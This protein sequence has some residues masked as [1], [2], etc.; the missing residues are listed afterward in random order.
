M[1]AL[2]CCATSLVNAYRRV[3][4]APM[5]PI[6]QPCQ[7]A[8]HLSFDSTRCGQTLAGTLAF[9]HPAVEAAVSNWA[10]MLQLDI[11]AGGAS[12]WESSKMAKATNDSLENASQ[13]SNGCGPT[14]CCHRD[15]RSGLR[16]TQR[17][18]CSA[19]SELPCPNAAPTLL[20]QSWSCTSLWYRL[21]RPLRTILPRHFDMHLTERAFGSPGCACLE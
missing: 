4:I 21:L 11:H 20:D 12:S 14:C 15:E 17:R 16:K 18:P 5:T 2:R 9:R 10:Y 8:A 19:Q 13:S 7:T 1:C 6:Y 3:T